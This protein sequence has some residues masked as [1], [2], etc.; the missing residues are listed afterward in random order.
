MLA[1]LTTQTAAASRAGSDSGPAAAGSGSSG[2]A[3]CEDAFLLGLAD[4][5]GEDV[6]LPVSCTSERRAVVLSEAEPPPG[7]DAGVVTEAA[8]GDV[9]TPGVGEALEV[10]V[11]EGD[12]LVVGEGE[13]LADADGLAEGEGTV[14]VGTGVGR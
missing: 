3:L 13:V 6:R 10:T 5:Q 4:G 1:A 14:S 2:D 11:G 8:G 7:L 12:G 9:V